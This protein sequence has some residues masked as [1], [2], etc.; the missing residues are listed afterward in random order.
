MEDHWTAIVVTCS[1]A[2]IREGL[3]KECNRLAKVGMLPSHELLMVVDDP[4]WEKL[5]EE[6]SASKTCRLEQGVGS[7]GA[8]IN[9]LLVAVERL[10]AKRNHTTISSEL[11]YNSR[12]LVVHHGRNLAHSPGGSPFLYVP[13]DLACVSQSAMTTPPT[14]LQ[15]V[16]WMATKV[17]RKS[18]T[19]VWVTSLDA[20]IPNSP[21]V[22]A[23]DTDG[24][25]GA[26]VCTIKTPLQQ[27]THHGTVITDGR[28][29]ILRMEYKMPWDR[30]KEV[31]TK[32]EAPVISGLVFLSASLTEQLLGLHT[33]P[34]LDRCT[35]YGTDS[36]IPPLQVSLYFDL[37]LPL[38]SNVEEEEYLSGQCGAVYAQVA[39]YNITA[40]Q[41]LH[42]A[43]LQIWKQLQGLK[44]EFHSLEGTRHHYLASHLTYESI[45]LPLLS[46]SCVG[47]RHFQVPTSGAVKTIN[48]YIEGSVKSTGKDLF[49]VDSWIGKDVALEFSGLSTVSGFQLS[50]AKLQLKIAGDCVWQ[51]H[52]TSIQDVITCYGIKDQLSLHYQ[53]KEASIFN[54]D[55]PVFMERTG[56][57]PDILWPNQ[58]SH[59]QTF[60][61]AKLFSNN[62]SKEEQ[63]QSLA[64]LVRTLTD[65]VMN[66]W[67]SRIEKW[68]ANSRFSLLDAVESSII[69]KLIQQHEDIYLKISE[70]IIAATSSELGGKSLLPMF[71]YVAARGQ[72]SVNKIMMVLHQQLSHE[73]PTTPRLLANIADLLGCMAAGDGGLRSGP[74][75]NPQWRNALQQLKSGNQSRAME[76][77]F[78]TC[79]LWMQSGHPED[80][81]RAARHYERASQIVISHLVETA[82]MHV[83]P[84]WVAQEFRQ[85]VPVGVWVEAL[86]PARIDL[87][88]GWTDTPPIC[89]EQGGAV[90]NIAIK[91]NKK[92]PIG[93]RV[94]F[95]PEPHIVCVL[96]DWSGGDVR[97]T[98]SQLEQ[99]GDYDN[100]VAPGA[101]VK[102]VLLYCR[103]V[104]LH[105]EDT[106]TSQLTERYNAGVEVEVWSQL[107]QGSGLGGSSLLAGTLVS[108]MAVLLG[109]PPPS[110][111]HLVHA[112]LTIEQRLTTGGGWQDQVGGLVG[113]A[114]LGVS[115]VGTP[116][117]VNMYKIPLQAEML[118]FLNNHLLLLYTGKVRLARNLLQTVIRNW[119]ARDSTIIECFSK[120]QQLA[121]SA[122][123]AVL[124]GDRKELGLC[125]D[126]Y[127]SLKKMV[128]S[129]CEPGKVKK[130][131]SSLRNHCLGMSLAGAGGGGY[132][133]AL[134]TLSDPLPNDVI[135]GELSIDTVEVDQEGLELWVGGEP[136]RTPDNEE[137]LTAEKLRSLH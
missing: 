124:E 115:N 134:K 7:G 75:A 37:L 8:T 21:Q 82:E 57:S 40:V 25:N 52:P 31:F 41:E 99:L 50:G 81:I 59:N 60:L 85:Q 64:I 13:P 27:A 126:K 80:L 110:H 107:P 127:W 17:G 112:T 36:G 42:T 16:I 32:D 89:Y 121:I 129:G 125:I 132:L 49:I 70:Q 86:S 117:T 4:Q 128:A 2:L 74:A 12:I 20:F 45:I 19:G 47:S 98:W 51:M 61:T 76:L 114:K 26:V 38:C 44:A 30:M 93:A 55:W 14:L 11:V 56:L 54:T 137:I 77:M 123:A 63:I 100:P 35:Y 135:P 97:L 133:Y 71:E 106:L 33:L 88:G 111:S 66:E 22:E 116:V 9:A 102:V 92:K 67:K 1:T 104:D 131:M 78:D 69:H 68:K 23:P 122:A 130:L 118:D 48:A 91:I 84:M 28:K 5:S 109:H 120:L 43:R 79:K 10:S 105:S 15:H 94:R 24:V 103:L 53:E 6:G 113:G 29:N 95:I 62:I 18:N 65:D 58:A 136:L 39:K 108:A 3:E 90:L 119:Y 83:S 101:L 73:R 72:T 34:P 46:S 96:R 87:A